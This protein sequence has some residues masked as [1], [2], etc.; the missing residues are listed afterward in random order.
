MYDGIQLGT[1]CSH[2][3]FSNLNNEMFILP[4]VFTSCH[5]LNK[6]FSHLLLQFSV[7]S[8]SVGRTS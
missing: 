3:L 4:E 2:L 7:K 5:N 1:S 6:N 8:G